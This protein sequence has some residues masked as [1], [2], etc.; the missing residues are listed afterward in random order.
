MKVPINNLN[1]IFTRF[2]LNVIGGY[3]YRGFYMCGNLF[4]IKKCYLV[5]RLGDM[6][7]SRIFT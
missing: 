3:F 1:P 4:T 5:F 2:P 6:N 7:F